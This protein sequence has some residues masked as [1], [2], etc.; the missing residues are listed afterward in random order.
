MKNKSSGK[1]F[2]TFLSIIAAIAVAVLFWLV[3]KY[4]D[5]NSLTAVLPPDMYGGTV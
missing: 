4:I 1:K 5:A 3:V 2:S